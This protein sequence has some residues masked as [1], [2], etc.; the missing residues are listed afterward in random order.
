MQRPV[1]K[2]LLILRLLVKLLSGGLTGLEHSSRRLSPQKEGKWSGKQP[3]APEGLK[4]A[5]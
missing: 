1:L 3:G 5:L 4:S 2:L